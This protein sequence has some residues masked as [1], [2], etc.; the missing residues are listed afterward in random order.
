MAN[1]CLTCSTAQ[2]PQIDLRASRREE[3]R[4]GEEGTGGG[5]GGEGRGGEGRG[6][7]KR[8]RIKRR[9]TR[10]FTNNNDFK[11]L[12]VLLMFLLLILTWFVSTMLVQL[13]Y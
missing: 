12:P 1:V 3:K 9:K 7:E 6:G 10:Q 4:R 13:R 5:R 8:E 2:D 11:S